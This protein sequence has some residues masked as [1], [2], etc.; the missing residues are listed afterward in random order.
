MPLESEPHERTLMQWPVS[1]KV[2]DRPSLLR[3]QQAIARIA[4]TI[5]NYEP[6]AMMADK[7]YHAAARKL[8]NP[9]V[10][11]WDIPTDDLWCRDS[12][13][14]FVRRADGTLAIS[15]IQF[16][17]W[18]NK[19]PHANDAG[20]AARVAQRLGLPLIES[21]LVGEQGGVEHDGAG[22]LLAHASCWDNSNRNRLPRAAI[23]RRLLRAIG[24][25]KMIWAPG[26]KGKDITDYHIDALARFVGPGKVLIQLSEEIDP[27]DPWSVSGHETLRILQRS[28]DAS[29]RP[30]DIVRLPDPLD[31]RATS[32]DFVS[33]YVN[34]YVCN[35]AVIAAQFGDA[36]VDAL[37]LEQL[38][39]L[40]PGRV[41]EM[42]DVDA[43][44]ESGGGIHCATQQQ[45]KARRA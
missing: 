3:V 35:G 7:R 44:G 13:P 26:I 40:Y 20:I 29:G 21:G 19:Q 28:T 43:I 34:Y 5:S 2:Y 11:L 42:L 12:G 16:N 38:Q 24:G 6:V 25:R 18:G 4:N 1:L 39:Q 23:E 22:T 36:A 9:R 10:E 17:G 31:I 41:V 32:D 27:D 14:T 15:H 33:S 30:L 8:L 37:A 45:P